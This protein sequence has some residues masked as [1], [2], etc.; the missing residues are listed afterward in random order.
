MSDIDA[1]QVA[2]W[3]AIA[4]VGVPHLINA[5]KWFL[6]REVKRSE[7]EKKVTD[8]KLKTADARLE[9]FET[10]LDGLSARVEQVR[11]AGE[12]NH[13]SLQR[14]FNALQKDNGS[15]LEAVRTLDTRIEKRLEQMEINTRQEITR[16]MREVMHEAQT[17][18]SRKK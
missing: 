15:L 3:G 6:G 10:R 1:G 13:L 2:T 9:G 14:D 8:E 11:E 5:V 7:D 12:K 18:P 4:L 16:A 17:K